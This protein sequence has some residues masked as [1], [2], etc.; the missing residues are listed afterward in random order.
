MDPDHVISD[1]RFLSWRRPETGAVRAPDLGFSLGRMEDIPGHWPSAAFRPLSAWTLGSRILPA[2]PGA[3]G[4][5]HGRKF[6]HHRTSA[7]K[8][9]LSAQAA[10]VGSIMAAGQ[11]RRV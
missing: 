10:G 11:D 4:K 2:V 6:K 1:G 3:G 7:V 8:G 9:R 5:H